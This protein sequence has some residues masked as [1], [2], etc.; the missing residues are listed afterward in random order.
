MAQSVWRLSSP[1]RTRHAL[2]IGSSKHML[3][4]SP[5]GV[6]NL[7]P[8]KNLHTEVYGSFIPNCQKWRPSRCPS[9]GEWRNK[10]WYIHAME[11]YSVLKRNALSS[12]ENIEES[13]MYI[14]K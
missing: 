8:H 5:K 13:Y 3:K 10:L 7:C 12:H 9:V 14:T 2:P 6:E 1:Y 4:Y 11:Y